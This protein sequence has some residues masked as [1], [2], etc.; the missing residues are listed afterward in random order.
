MCS[1]TSDT[2]RDFCGAV[3]F[4]IKVSE[5][6]DLPLG[7]RCRRDGVLSSIADGFVVD[8]FKISEHE[9]FEC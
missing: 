9:S 1:K 2:C 5:D 3:F 6:L 7:S 4:Q 8:L